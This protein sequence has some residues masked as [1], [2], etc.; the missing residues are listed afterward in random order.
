MLVIGSIF[1][2]TILILNFYT[3]N[4][5]Q[6]SI[7]VNNEAIITAA[8]IGQ[9]MIDNILT[10]AFDEATISQSVNTVDSL[11]TAI[12][13]GPDAGEVYTYQFD[14]VDDFKNFAAVDSSTRLSNYD[15]SVDVN[16]VVKLT[17]G[18]ISASR[19]FTKRIDV[20]VWSQYLPDTLTISHV[21]AY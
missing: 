1:L 11:A 12:A 7:S 2:I 16:Y 13:L 6:M 4:T 18:T 14:D 9:A 10:R 5:N 21:I 20:T 15:I 19:T 3:A 17:P 8:G